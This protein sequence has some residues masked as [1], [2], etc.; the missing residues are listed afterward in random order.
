ME[1]LSELPQ[2]KGGKET[3][4]KMTPRGRHKKIL[5]D[6]SLG[7]GRG[8]DAARG[9]EGKGKNGLITGVQSS[10]QGGR[11]DSDGRGTPGLSEKASD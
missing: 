7:G 11:V 9:K 10:V 8:H 3:S 4:G 6:R 1:T 2:G 5:T